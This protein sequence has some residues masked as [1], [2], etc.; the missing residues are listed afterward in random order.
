M[1][2]S[3]AKRQHFVLKLDVAMAIIVNLYMTRRLKSNIRGL[4][5]ARVGYEKET[6]ILFAMENVARL[7]TNPY[8]KALVGKP[9]NSNKLQLV[10][11]LFVTW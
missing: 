5:H 2:T 7:I 3:E 11:L 9:I 10:I 8:Y 1:N 6:V 4:R